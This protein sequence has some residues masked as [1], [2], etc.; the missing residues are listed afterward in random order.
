MDA[1]PSTAWYPVARSDDLPARHVYHGQVLGREVA[2]WRADDGYVN[3][4]ENRCL[5]RGV[6]L[7]LGLNEGRELRCQY[8]GW[9]YANRTAGCTY[10]PAQP[11]DSPARTVCNLTLPAVERHGLVWTGE[12]PVGEPPSP[13]VL[14]D[15]RA[16]GL[17][18]LPVN[19]APEVVLAFLEDYRF[20]PTD[21]VARDVGATKVEHAEADAD[22]DAEVEVSITGRGGSWIELTARAGDLASTVVLFVQPLDVTRSVVRG[23]LAGVTAPHEADQ[24][25]VLRHHHRQLSKTRDAIERQAT[26]RPVAIPRAAS[27]A[28]PAA[29]P[30]AGPGPVAATARVDGGRQVRFP[31]IVARRWEAGS[32]IAGFELRP[33]SGLLPTPQPGGHIDVHL[34][35]GLVRQYSLVNGPGETDRYVIGVK[36]EPDSRGGSVFLHDTVTVG[37]ELIVSEPRNNFPLR[38]DSFRTILVAGGIGITPLLAMAQALHLSHLVFELHCFVQSERHLAFREIVGGLG[39]SATRHLGLSPEQTATELERL[40]AVPED[41]GHVYV[42]GPGPMLDAARRVAAAAGWPDGAVHF[43]YFKNTTELDTTSSFRVELARSGLTLAVPAGASIMQVLRDA[44][45]DVASSCEQGACGTCM[46][47]V[48]AG[49]PDHQDVYLNESERRAG[50]RMAICVS[51]A[52]SELLVLDR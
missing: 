8:H 41:G 39:D 7:T 23:V 6:R 19:E 45:V 16:F 28:A 31:V 30:P 33:V 21:L 11:A 10:I 46:T 36:R 15:G 2:I 38:R 52:R 43:E 9:R 51:R 32:D 50:D 14:A 44:G 29:P 40:L 26:R 49:E 3:V 17:R 4:W 12:A 25:W 13:A 24:L 37:D 1:D 22:A 34:P 27:T 48:L 47:T 18:N 20:R 5:H 42:C 35:T